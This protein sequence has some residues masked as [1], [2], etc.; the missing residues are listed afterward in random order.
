MAFA[1][2][3]L[4]EAIKSSAFS[5]SSFDPLIIKTWAISLL[6]FPFFPAGTVSVAIVVMVA[7]VCD[8]RRFK[9]IPLVPIT[10]RTRDAGHRNS[11][12]ICPAKIA[13]ASSFAAFATAAAGK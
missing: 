10:Y 6:S 9:M 4:T 2:F 13:A 11:F 7:P 3:A 1:P 8:M 12:V 5:T